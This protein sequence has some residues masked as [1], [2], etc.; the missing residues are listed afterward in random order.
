MVRLICCK[1]QIQQNFWERIVKLESK[2]SVKL[3]EGALNF[4]L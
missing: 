1:G 3:K 4:K 2:F